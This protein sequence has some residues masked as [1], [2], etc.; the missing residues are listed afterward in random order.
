MTNSHEMTIQSR[1]PAAKAAPLHWIR[2]E[3][4][5]DVNRSPGFRTPGE[6]GCD[7]RHLPALLR[8]MEAPYLQG[9]GGVAN[10]LQPVGP[11]AGAVVEVRTVRRV[12]PSGEREVAGYGS[13]QIIGFG[14]IEDVEAILRR[15]ALL[16]AEIAFPSQEDDDSVTV[17]SEYFFATGGSGA[18]RASAA[19]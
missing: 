2:I 18:S 19:E 9:G 7:D 15:N 10:M 8:R 1:Q 3:H 6:F 13:P 14:G 4:C 16:L 12:G 11:Y 17:S 5:P